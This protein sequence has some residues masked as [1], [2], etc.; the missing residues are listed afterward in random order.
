MLK[1]ESVQLNFVVKASC[2]K[3]AN[4]EKNKEEVLFKKTKK[5]LFSKIT[6]KQE[7]VKQE[8]CGSK[9]CVYRLQEA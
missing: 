1:R 8:E 7:K 5:K 2:K 3:K 6:K 4:C 9:S